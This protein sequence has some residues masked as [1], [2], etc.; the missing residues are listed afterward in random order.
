MAANYFNGINTFGALFDA[1]WEAM[2]TRELIE[3]RLSEQGIQSK[4][5]RKSKPPTARQT[6]RWLAYPVQQLQGRTVRR[7]FFD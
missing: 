6:R 3:P 7:N 2:I 5:Y 4:S 1:Y